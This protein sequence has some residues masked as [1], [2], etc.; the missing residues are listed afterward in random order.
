MGS[1]WHEHSRSARP[2]RIL[3]DHGGPVPLSAAARWSG[4]RRLAAVG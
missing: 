1:T 3:T 4:L 2:F